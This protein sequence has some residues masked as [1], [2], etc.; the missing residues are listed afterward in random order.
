MSPSSST[1][2]ISWP[3]RLER[4]PTEPGIYIM[5]DRQGEVIYIGKAANLRARLRSYFGRSGDTRWFVGLLD[6]LLGDIETIVVANE[7]EALL[8]ENTLIKR[9]QPRFNVKLRDDK[10]FLLLRVDTTLPYPRVELVRRV[11]EDR[12]RYFGPYPSARTARELARL[13]NRYFRLCTCSP[14]ARAR[15][16]RPCLRFAMGHCSG[17]CAGLVTPEDYARDVHAALLFLEGRRGELASMLQARMQ[18]AAEALR[19]E[20]AARLR[21]QLRM[22]ERAAERQRMVLAHQG[23][24]DFHALARAGDA[25]AFSTLFLRQGLVSGQ[26][27][28]VVTGMEFPDEEVLSQYIN[29]YYDSGAEVPPTVVVPLALEDAGTKEEWLGELRGARVRVV[30]PRR[31]DQKRLLQT[32]QRNA[33]L[34]LAPALEDS[35]QQ[36]EAARRLA[37]RLGLP[38]PPQRIECA[39]ISA[40]HGDQAVGSVVS[41]VVGKPDKAHYRRY[42]IRT[43]QGADDFA[44]M[45]EVLGRRLR[46]G[47]Q[48]GDLPD[49]LVVDGGK[50][51][52]GVAEGVAAELGLTGRPALAGLAKSRVT[53]LRSDG[54]EAAAHSEERVFLPGRDEAVVLPPH[55]PECHLLARI[56]DE[57]HRFAITYHRGR[58]KKSTVRSSLDGI[59]GVGPSRRRQLLQRFG[60]VQAVRAASPEELAQLPGIGPQLADR[61]LR[62]LGRQV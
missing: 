50:G 26:R 45:R 44:M 34:A 53:G 32:A 59:P 19:F 11:T 7:K 58:R 20:D 60:S 2:S 17:A 1:A 28:M 27:T 55:T 52:L 23:D 47:Q 15:R 48:E 25:V 38:T 14:G 30:Q 49:L 16:T 13:A 5:R 61:I 39:D 43:V 40:F 36:Q 56:R 35:G 51:Q 24:Q 54:S 10:A 18:E 21:D 9:H 4:V 41:F 62:A 12:A 22:V 31:G 6:R 8:L 3:E 46:R 57:A 29:L 42:R 37:E 33:T